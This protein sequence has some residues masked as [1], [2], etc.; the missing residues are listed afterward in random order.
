MKTCNEC[1]KKYVHI[2]G[3]T[4][5]R[6]T[7]KFCTEECRKSHVERRLNLVAMP[8]ASAANK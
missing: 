8:P 7:K 5:R 4:A 6:Y 2:K 3:P 1:G